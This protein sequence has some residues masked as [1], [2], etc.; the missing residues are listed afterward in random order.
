MFAQGPIS[1]IFFWPEET[2]TYQSHLAV[3]A[4]T[5]VHG[6]KCIGTWSVRTH[7]IQPT[8]IHSETFKRSEW[9]M[10]TDSV[11]IL[12]APYCSPAP[13]YATHAVPLP[14][15]SE[16]YANMARLEPAESYEIARAY[17]GTR[18]WDHKVVEDKRLNHAFIT[19][20]ALL[21]LWCTVYPEAGIVCIDDTIGC[22]NDCRNI[23]VYQG[24]TLDLDHGHGI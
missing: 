14:R 10:S 13:A 1:A 7:C 18:S 16:A 22:H 11:P 21:S 23:K 12:L 5:W 24:G 9:L 6:A 3:L 15:V 20:F 2:G 8:T 17:D 19:I 4:E